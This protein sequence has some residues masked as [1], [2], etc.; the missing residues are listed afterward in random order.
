MK[1]GT[2]VTVTGTGFDK[3]E[4]VAIKVNGTQ[5]IVKT[6]TATGTVE[7]SMPTGTLKKGPTTVELTGAKSKRSAKATLEVTA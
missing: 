3:A 4:Q 6:A 5:K 2:S 7:W 1:A